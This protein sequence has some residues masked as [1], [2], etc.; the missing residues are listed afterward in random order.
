[1]KK[2]IKRFDLKK[3]PK[4]TLFL[5]KPLKSVYANLGT[6]GHDIKI[7]KTNLEG[8]KPP[9]LL[10]GNHNA[11]LDT[12]VAV[13]VLGK[14]ESHFVIAID[15]FLGR[16]W[17][18]RNIGS[19]GK[20]KFTNDPNLIWHLKH[21]VNMGD[22][23]VLFPEARYSLCGTTAVLP[24]SLGMLCKFLKV[25]VVMLRTHGHHINHPF[26]NTSHDRGVKGLE[27]EMF[28][29]F[30]EDE[31]KTLSPDEINRR[32]VEAFQYDDFAWQKEKG[33]KVDD[34]KRAEGLHKVLYQCPCCGKE[35]SMSSSGT[36][37][38]CDACQKEWEMTDLGEL[39]ALDGKDVFTHIPDWYEWERKNVQEE[40]KNGTYSSGELKVQ[41]ESLPNPKKYIKLGSGT[42]VHDMNGFKVQGIDFDGD[43]FEMIKPVESMYSCH[44]EY[45]YLF[46][47]GDCVD[48]NTLDDT[49]YIYPE[50]KD[51]AVTKMAL[52]TEELYFDY[53]RKNG[54]PVK[55]GLA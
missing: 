5:F 10:L 13:K 40:I 19:I 11:L 50:G 4:K 48:L 21:C 17:L 20:R 44:I 52:A 2:D 23:P 24:E 16:E 7:T 37:L 46:K 49:W 45:N 51:F 3:Q 18:I 28:L 30:T 54:K 55:K 33:I 34:P 6:R 32:L 26:W 15:G 14:A 41:V 27:E 35:F 29:L 38:K 9:F 42:L 8:I 47:H 43:P 31:V 22:V 36:R 12:N 1:M 53:L 25:P 39:K